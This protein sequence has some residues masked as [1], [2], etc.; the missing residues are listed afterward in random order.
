[1]SI[2]ISG[3]EAGYNNFKLNKINTSIKAGSLTALIGPNGCGK[4]TL[5][6]VIARQLPVKAGAITI[7]GQNVSGLTRRGFAKLISILPQNPLVPEGVTI[8]QLVGYGRAPHQN[9]LGWQTDED[10]RQVDAAI[11][12]NELCQ[13]K[14]MFVSELSGGQRQRAFLAMCMAQDT[15]YIL[16]DEPTSAL[17]IK[18]QYEVLESLKR[19]KQSGKTIIVVL[20][21][22]AQSARYADDIIVMRA[23]QVEAQ[24]DPVRVITEEL[25]RKVYDFDATVY[26]DPETGLPA[27]TATHKILEQPFG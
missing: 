15:P 12:Q 17:D 22:I 2:E 25:I 5:L 24:G 8:E 21:D 27:I 19:L 4:S 14:D 11:E 20:H 9:L 10:S 18:Y 26:S 13:F 6:K 1:M 23:G 3:I 16:L 7:A